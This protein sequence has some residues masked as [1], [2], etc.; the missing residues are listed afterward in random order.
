MLRWFITIFIAV[1]VFSAALPWLEKFG[2]GRLPGDIR[3]K[4]FGKTIFSI[5]LYRFVIYRHLFTGAPVLSGRGQCLA[6]DKE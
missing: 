2:I 1:I 5:R 6:R 4:L 3:F